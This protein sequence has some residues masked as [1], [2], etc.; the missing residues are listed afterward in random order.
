M[1]ILLLR[2]ALLSPLFAFSQSSFLDYLYHKRECAIW[3]S[4]RNIGDFKGTLK[5]ISTVKEN[6]IPKDYLMS[7][8]AV[9]SEMYL[10]LGDSIKAKENLRK[11]V[12]SGTPSMFINYLKMNYDT[13]S[14]QHHEIILQLEQEYTIYYS[15]YR[16]SLDEKLVA[17]CDEMY[18]ND[19]SVRNVYHA[20]IQSKDML[21]K[22]SVLAV[23]KYNDEVNIKTY[24]SIVDANGWV[25]RDRAG[26]QMK[27]YHIIVAHN[28]SSYR[29]KYVKLGYELA[30]QNKIGWQELIGIQS[31][32]FIKSEKKHEKARF[33]ENWVLD[34]KESVSNDF[35]LMIAYCLSKDIMD[36]GTFNGNEKRIKLYLNSTDSNNSKAL[37]KLESL[38]K[39]LIRFGADSSKI[40]I[41]KTSI[42]NNIDGIVKNCVGIEYI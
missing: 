33:I 18:N 31:F 41:D 5:F 6:S 8:Y 27:N 9:Q 20:M 32:A 24:D 38:K 23:M 37:E 16:K 25:Y 1:R 7:Y 12:F 21:K 4:T 42:Y 3:D 30:K 35:N 34:T 15:E 11:A 36:G 14:Q 22:D 26:Y 13:V 28:A 40:E 2:L 10:N 29:Y 39:E 17:I 19:Q